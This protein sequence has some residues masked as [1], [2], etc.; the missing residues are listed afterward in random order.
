M[1]SK[2][3]QAVIL[4]GSLAVAGTASANDRNVI[5]P[6][7]AGAAVGAVLATLISHSGRNDYQQPRYQHYQ[8]RPRYAPQYQP[9]A[10][11]PVRRQVVYRRVEPVYGN[12]YDHGRNWHGDRG[13]NRGYDRG[14][15]RGRGDGRW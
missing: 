15:D 1:I 2:M 11:V 5:V 8:P 10:Y 14:Y 12:P 3:I 6:V 9:V 7:I 13:Y 4:S